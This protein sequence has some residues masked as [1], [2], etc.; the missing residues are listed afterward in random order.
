MPGACWLG[1]NQLPRSSSILTRSRRGLVVRPA[2]RP[3][4]RDVAY[5]FLAELLLLALD[6]LLLLVVLFFA[7]PDFEAALAMLPLLPP[8]KT[9]EGK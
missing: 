9:V 7:P 3:R 1:A 4:K 8:R 2:N 6:L 5:F